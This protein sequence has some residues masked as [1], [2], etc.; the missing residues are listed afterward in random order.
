MENM[1]GTRIKERRKELHITQAQ[2]KELTGISSGNMSEIE[3]GK[4]LP[5]SAALMQLS[6]AL[7]CTTD[8]ILFGNS[9]INEKS[10]PSNLRE[11]EV[12]LLSILRELPTS[13]QEEVLMIAELKLNRNQ[14]KR[15]TNL[16]HSQDDNISIA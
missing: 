11:I 10:F 5:S 6:K 8:Y 16:S 12:Q 4:I 9:S 13:D 15:E 3:N 7:N 1:I 14:R 2:I